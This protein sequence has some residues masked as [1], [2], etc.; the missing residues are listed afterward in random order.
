MYVSDRNFPLA[1]HGHPQERPVLTCEVYIKWYALYL[2]L[3]S[4]KI[5]E[6]DLSDIYDHSPYL[7]LVGETLVSD[8]CW[9]PTAI[10][11]LAHAKG[12][13]VDDVSFDL[14]VGRWVNDH[15][16]GLE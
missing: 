7:A 10:S 16:G 6:A 15:L 9:N 11:A 2:V 5:R 8:H 14:L 3:P 1:Y 12:W 13:I 4:G